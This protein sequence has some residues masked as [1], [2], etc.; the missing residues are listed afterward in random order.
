MNSTGEFKKS[1]KCRHSDW[2][3]RLMSIQMPR[4]SQWRRV[5][6]E[7]SLRESL[8]SAIF[9][10]RQAEISAQSIL[11]R[12]CQGGQTGQ[13]FRSR[14]HCFVLRRRNCD[15]SKFSKPALLTMPRC[16]GFNGIQCATHESELFALFVSQLSMGTKWLGPSCQ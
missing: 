14:D 3:C 8:H 15:N 4:L 7:K 10:L 6:V 16:A 2:V 12:G 11:K 1:R 5:S 13:T 9:L